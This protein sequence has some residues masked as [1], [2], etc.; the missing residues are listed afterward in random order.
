M[1]KELKQLEQCMEH[2]AYIFDE[3]GVTNAEFNN[4]TLSFK[5]NGTT[6]NEHLIHTLSHHI[7]HVR[8]D[9]LAI[10]EDELPEDY[11]D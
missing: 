2:L 3:L 10:G 5:H 11:F 1:S 8:K 6:I 7:S 9:E 4:G